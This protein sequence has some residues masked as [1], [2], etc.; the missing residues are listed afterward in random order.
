MAVLSNSKRVNVRRI[1]KSVDMPKNGRMTY[2]EQNF[3]LKNKYDMSPK[4]MAEV[5]GR[6]S[7]C[8]ITF[9]KRH[10]NI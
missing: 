4:Q 5:L 1:K 2:S 3:I 7:S 8:I 10:K 9:L 6:T